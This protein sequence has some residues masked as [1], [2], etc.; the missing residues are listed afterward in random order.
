MCL[1]ASLGRG[2]S[3][4]PKHVE[5]NPFPAEIQAKGPRN[6]NT[7]LLCDCESIFCSC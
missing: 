3:S 1:Q 7:A 4:S 6:I 5:K 2:F